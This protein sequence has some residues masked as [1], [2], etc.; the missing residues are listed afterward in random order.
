[1]SE[2]IVNTEANN[3]PSPTP[4][5]EPSSPA[6][7][8]DAASLTAELAQ[9]R[10]QL[11]Q[12]KPYMG[13]VEKASK[14]GYD[15]TVLEE[16]FGYSTAAR[17]PSRQNAQPAAAAQNGAL[18]EDKIASIVDTRLA[19]SDHQRSAASEPELIS[20]AAAELG[21]DEAF[22]ATAELLLQAEIQ[23]NR[24]HYPATHPLHRQ[25]L[26]P[27]TK[28]DVT[29]AKNA[30]AKHLANLNGA[31]LAAKATAPIASPAGSQIP[32]GGGFG[33]QKPGVPFHKQSREEQAQ[34][35]RQLRPDIGQGGAV[36]SR[37]A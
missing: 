8:A 23:K 37:S 25:A 16:A 15:P 30:V 11:E 3:N 27:V 28:A 12:V 29:A 2:S 14:D 4:P 18:S 33:S 1:M 6:L 26:Q 32:S 22:R 34:A 13:F 24:K 9:L 19:W 10:A 35:L 7:G 17:Q 20:A 36:S 21:P 5:A 31:R